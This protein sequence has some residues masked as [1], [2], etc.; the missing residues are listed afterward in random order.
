MDIKK[1]IRDAQAKIINNL[2]ACESLI[3]ELYEAFA[4]ADPELSKFWQD[5]A[6]EE[7]D[8]AK[9]LASLI[10]LLDKGAI[11][12]EIGRF[13]AVIVAP[14]M[15]LANKELQAAHL[16]PPSRL[17]AL[18]VALNLESSVF[19]AHFYKIV[20]SDSPEY[21]AT[22]SKLETDTQKHIEVVRNKILALQAIPD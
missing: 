15:N 11:F 14:V 16:T 20:H 21:Q 7:K 18:Q 12:R 2:I 6:D 3:A 13:D 22:A 8:H 4:K 5:I 1:R 17:H 19:D 9:Q 10:H